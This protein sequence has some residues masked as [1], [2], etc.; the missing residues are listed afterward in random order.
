MR[1]YETEPAVVE[2]IEE[3]EEEEEKEEE[4]PGRF[5]LVDL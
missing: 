1:I 4:F 2:D 5:G 3:S